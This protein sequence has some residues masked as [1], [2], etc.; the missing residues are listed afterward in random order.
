MLRYYLE[1]P[2]T[3]NNAATLAAEGGHKSTTSGSQLIKKYAEFCELQQGE[4]PTDRKALTHLEKNLE[5]VLAL[6]AG[7]AKRRAEVDLKRVS[8]KKSKGF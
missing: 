2:L 7:E 8:E 1:Q 5:Y 6:L 3:D 4:L